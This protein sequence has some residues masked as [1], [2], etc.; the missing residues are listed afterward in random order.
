MDGVRICRYDSVYSDNGKYGRAGCR[1]CVFDEFYSVLFIKQEF[2]AV[3]AARSKKKAGVQAEQQA[4]DDVY[5]RGKAS[6]CG[7]R[8]DGA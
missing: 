7:M 8:K 1:D 4:S 5:K 3:Y 2:Q 6:L